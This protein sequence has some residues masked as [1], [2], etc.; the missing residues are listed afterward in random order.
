MSRMKNI[1]VLTLTACLCGLTTGCLTPHEQFVQTRQ[2]GNEH[3]SPVE[4]LEQ[5]PAVKG[6]ELVEVR[7][8]PGQSVCLLRIATGSELALSRHT[9]T[10]ITLIALSGAATLRLED[11]RYAVAPGQVVTIPR[12]SNY[13]IRPV[14]GT[15]GFA[16]LIV[17]SPAYDPGDVRVV[18]D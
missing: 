1:A 5:M 15:D 9:R 16:A 17:Y 10:D 6:C 8:S 14:D 3:F 12:M 4:L 2:P 13:A 11:T 7:R 18:E